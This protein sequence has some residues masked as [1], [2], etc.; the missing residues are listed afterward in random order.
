[1]WKYALLVLCG[2]ALLFDC[3]AGRLLGNYESAARS[4]TEELLKKVPRRIVNG[5]KAVLGQ[6]PQQVSL[7]RR[8]SQSHFCGGSILTPDWVLTAGHCMLDNLGK[9][10]G[11]YTIIVIAGEI[12]LKNTNRARQWSYVSERIVHPEFDI[13]TLHNDVA[14]L[15]VETPFVFDPYVRPAPVMRD[16]MIPHTEC[17]VAGWGR[18]QYEGPISAYLLFVD[19]PLLPIPLCRELL[20]NYSSIPPGMFCA[21]YLDGGRDACQGDSGGGMICEGYLTGVVSGGE[22][23]AWPRLPGL[24]ADVKYYLPWIELYVELN[25]NFTIR[26]TPFNGRSS[27]MQTTSTFMILVFVLAEIFSL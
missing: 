13:D 1:M 10:I 14:L 23:C 9:V 2:V 3:T 19:V 16:K 5:T 25:N 12:V 22:G 4:N 6:F 15:R 11:A 27:A 20:Y 24:Y 7:R 17:Q 21:G 18:I 26:S 8:Y